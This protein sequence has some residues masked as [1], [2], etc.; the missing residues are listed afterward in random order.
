VALAVVALAAPTAAGASTGVCPNEELRSELRSGRLPECRAYEMVTPPY[1]EGSAAYYNF[2]VSEDGSRL[3]ASSFVGAYAGAEGDT[4]NLFSPLAGVVYEYTRGLAGWAARSLTPSASEYAGEGIFDIGANLEGGL[5][6]LRRLSQPEG[7]TNLYLE[8]PWG[9]FTEIGPATPNPSAQNSI[10]YRYA[11]ASGNLSHV[12]FTI[13][14]AGFY[15]SFD[16]TVNGL[17]SLYEYVGR[18]KAVPSLVGVGGESEGENTELISDCGTRLGSSTPEGQEGSMYNAISA[19]GERIFFT[20]VGADDDIEP[21]TGQQPPVDE[22]FAREETAGG[23]LRTIPISEPSLRYCLESPPSPCADGHFEGASQDGSKVFFTSTQRLLPDASEGSTNLYEYDF[24]RSGQTQQERLVLVSGG[25]G[26]SPGVKGVAR[27]SED[28]SHVYFVAEGDLTGATANGFGD[29]PSKEPGADNLYVFGQNEQSSG[30]HTSFVAT[31]SPG[32]AND[33][34]KADAR[35]V[36]AS[37]DGQFLVFT[38][39]SDITHEGIVP[40]VQQVFQ[41]DW[42]TGTLVRASIGQDGYNDNGRL[43]PPNASASL[44]QAG[45]H[46][47]IDSPTLD[48]SSLAPSDGAAF[49]ESVVALTPQALNDQTNSLGEPIPNIYEYRGGMVYLISDGQD[50][51]TVRYVP[52]PV[53]LGYDSSGSDVFFMTSDPLIPQD[54]D[55]QRD[56]YDARV[57]GGFPVSSSSPSCMAGACQGPLSPSPPPLTIGGS[58][59]QATEGNLPPVTKPAAKPKSSKPTHK[60]KLKGRRHGKKRMGLKVKTASK[61]AQS[62]GLHRG[63]ES[64]R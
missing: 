44:T 22:L 15:W 50:T 37:Q 6:E 23:G 36:L 24:D 1:K 30:G 29:S 38:S 5:W 55:T 42:K 17:P 20:A 56:I 9:R 46:A 16:K 47:E 39:E 13:H 14:K 54:T 31:L 48:N 25:G 32:D 7:V 12:L 19:Y 8:R 59:T 49:F 21:C 41:Y 10:G 62:V 53:L 40:G 11:G 3:I 2:A 45:N 60:A 28:G 34:A 18:E 58:D 26:S 4:L 51:S 33:W 64:M 43:A 52:G 61:V 57:D 63:G 27:V 35:P